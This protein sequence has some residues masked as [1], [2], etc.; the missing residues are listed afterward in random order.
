MDTFISISLFLGKD[1]IRGARY[2]AISDVSEARNNEDLLPALENNVGRMEISCDG[3]GLQ[4]NLENLEHLFR[5]LLKNAENILEHTSFGIALQLPEKE[6]LYG[7]MLTENL[8]AL[9]KTLIKSNRPSVNKRRYRRDTE[10][11]MQRIF[12]NK[13]DFL[14]QLCAAASI[15]IEKMRVLKE[16]NFGAKWI[17]S[18]EKA[19]SLLA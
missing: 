8:F 13:R 19:K 11:L 9:E 4:V 2:V 15:F 1:P 3:Q 16:P 10:H 6:T 7:F 18:L 14:L 17:A 12:L 5:S